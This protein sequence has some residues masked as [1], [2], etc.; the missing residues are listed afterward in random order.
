MTPKHWENVRSQTA[1]SQ[2][3][4]W[5]SRVFIANYG[6]GNVDNSDVGNNK[7]SNIS[8]VGNN[9][10]KN[11]FQRGPKPSSPTRGKKPPMN[12]RQKVRRETAPSRFPGSTPGV[13]ILNYGSESG[14]V[15]NLDSDVANTGIVNPTISN[16][17]MSDN[18]SEDHFQ[19][20]PKPTHGDGH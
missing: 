19:P 1:P 18:N 10:S 2:L 9:N 14:T 13:S 12:P 20:R 15:K 4:S 3:P 16:L 7:D 11:Y 5:T 6:S 8:N 17:N